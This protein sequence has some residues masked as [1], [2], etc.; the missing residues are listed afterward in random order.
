MFAEPR[1]PDGAKTRDRAAPGLHFREI[2][3]HGLL[4]FPDVDVDIEN[5]RLT[6][7]R[8][9]KDCD[10]ETEQQEFHRHLRER[11]EGSRDRVPGSR[12]EQAPRGRTPRG[13]INAYCGGAEESTGGA[14]VEFTS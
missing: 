14:L 3:F 6:G 5:G 8:E 1:H 11:R 4:A 13:T 7:C 9:R 2:V 10:C 12:L